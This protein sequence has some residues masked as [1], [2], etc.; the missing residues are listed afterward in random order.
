[1]FGV[2][3]HPSEWTGFDFLVLYVTDRPLPPK[4]SFSMK[5]LALNQDSINPL[6]CSAFN[7]RSPHLVF[8]LCKIFPVRDDVSVKKLSLDN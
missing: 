5:T 8:H 3:P 4:P 6:H 2:S 1:M 7:I